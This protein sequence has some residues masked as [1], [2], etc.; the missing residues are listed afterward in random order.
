MY[1]YQRDQLEKERAKKYS[2]MVDA[3]TI[4]NRKQKDKRY[5]TMMT[6]MSH[7]YGNV[8][9]WIQKYVLDLMPDDLFK[10]VHVN[11]KIAHRQIR[12][13]D[14]EF[15]KKSKPMIIFRPRIAG[16]DEDRF[17]KGTSLIERQYDIYNTWGTTNL[18]PFF[19]DPQNDLMIKYQQNRSVMYVDVIMIFA[20]L[21]NQI[22]Y[23]HYLQNALPWN[24]SKFVPT[25]LESYIPQEMLKIISDITGKPLF[26]K[27]NSTR[28]F[29]QYL[30]QNCQT[31]VTYKLQGSTGTREFYRYYPTHIDTT[32]TDLNWDDGEKVGHIMNQ[33]QVTFS[34][35]LEFYS[36]GFYYV[37]SDN[38]YDLNLPKI[39]AESSKV[40]P[41]FTDVLTRDDLNLRPGWHLFN[42]ASCRLEK[43]FDSI[44]ID[45][46]LNNSIRAN[47]KYHLDNGLPL[48]EFLDIK[49]RRQG[50][51]IHEG[52]D[53]KIDYNTMTIYFNNKSPFYTYRILVCV[54][55][56]YIN[57]MVKSIYNL[58]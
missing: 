30:E 12:S 47:I 13:T 7:T 34:I 57:D 55:V 15:L 36:T 54:N 44:C 33:Y 40:I 27:E 10:T 48:L 42:K 52:T 39:D 35:K 16:M 49:V 58:K 28:E 2:Q 38:I 23:V 31:P 3:S 21:M 56:E 20:T 51:L 1:R 18:Q 4:Q 41:V 25:F 17:L 32:F 46:L 6:S 29:L 50:E 43:E 14:H 45:E 11:S 19:E 24:S 5:V 9:A 22:D 37:F 8:L 26:D 53:Y